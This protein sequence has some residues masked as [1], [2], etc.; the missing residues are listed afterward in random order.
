MT[1]G[2][3]LGEWGVIEERRNAS[4]RNHGSRQA[5]RP[6][7][8]VCERGLAGIEL[9]DDAYPQ[10]PLQAKLRAPE[11]ANGGDKRGLS[12]SGLF[13][14]AAGLFQFVEDADLV[15]RRESASYRGGSFGG[16]QRGCARL[17]NRQEST[18]AT[19]VLSPRPRVKRAEEQHVRDS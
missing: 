15:H 12:G 19:L 14:L 3:N 9:P 11:G 18:H 16:P 1:Y 4:V 10:R 2:R 8:K 13:K 7:K 6:R 5:F 17:S